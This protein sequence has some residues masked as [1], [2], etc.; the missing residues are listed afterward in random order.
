MGAQLLKE[1]R[2]LLPAWLIALCLVLAP[3]TASRLLPPHQYFLAD[4]FRSLVYFGLAL[5]PLMLSSIAFGREFDEGTFGLLLSQPVSRW[6]LWWEKTGMVA[7]ALVTFC[8]AVLLATGASVLPL[9]VF[10]GIILSA[11]GGGLLCSLLV[12]QTLGA[13]CLGALVP[14]LLSVV[15]SILAAVRRTV[16]QPAATTAR[17][18]FWASVAWAV[19]AYVAA[20][21]LFLTREDGAPSRALAVSGFRLRGAAHPA[22]RVSPWRAL[23]WK[24]LHLQQWSIYLGLALPVAT[25]IAV[26]L[27][28]LE[29]QSGARVAGRFAGLAVVGVVVLTATVPA[30]IGLTTVAEERRGGTLAWQRTLPVPQWKQFGLKLGVAWGLGLLCTPWVSIVLGDKF[31]GVVIAVAA[32]VLLTVFASSLASHVVEAIALSFGGFL[33]LVPAASKFLH[34]VQERRWMAL[35]A[36]VLAM[37]GVLIVLAGWNAREVIVSRRR[38]WATMAAI[39]VVAV[40]ASIR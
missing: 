26:A 4:A 27:A 1:A 5:G 11:Y 9:R 20:L 2:G 15:L 7:L 31:V 32:I 39:V 37:A 36:A 33:A 25:L 40:L 24:E 21:L 34:L 22:G 29:A 28:P 17:P 6:R 10:A 35:L 8:C 18:W 14:F 38:L 13:V 16:P 12:R 19:A 30:L 23:V 3:L